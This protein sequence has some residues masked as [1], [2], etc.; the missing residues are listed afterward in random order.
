MDTPLNHENIPTRYIILTPLNPTL[1][2]KT[3]VY[4]GMHYFSYFSSKHRL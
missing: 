4:R 2:S 1:Y 3:G